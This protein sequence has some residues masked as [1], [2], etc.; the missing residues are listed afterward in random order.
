RGQLRDHLR[1][2]QPVQHRGGGRPVARPHAEGDRAT[3]RCGCGWDTGG[4]LSQSERSLTMQAVADLVGGRLSGVGDVRITRVRSLE[5]AG[6]GALSVCSGNRFLDALQAT[7]ADAVLLPPDLA[8]AA[9]PEAR[10][11]VDDP[12]RAIAMVARALARP[13]PPPHID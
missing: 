6:P 11:V 1:R 12:L 3:Q 8:D 2:E 13:E 10:I 4:Q 9:G 5:G 7:H